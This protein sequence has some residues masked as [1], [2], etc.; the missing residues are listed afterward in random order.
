VLPDAD[1]E[2][3]GWNAHRFLQLLGSRSDGNN[4]SA[5]ECLASPYTIRT[6]PV[7]PELTEY[8]DSNY[9]VIELFNHYRGFAKSNWY[10]YLE[11]G[12]D[13]TVKRLL[14]VIR[15]VLFGEYVRKVKHIPPLNLRTFL[16]DAP[17]AVFTGIDRPKVEELID[18][19][20]AGRGDEKLDP[21]PYESCVEPFIEQ[22]IDYQELVRE[23][24]M[25]AETLDWYFERMLHTTS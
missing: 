11:S 1:I 14:H 6:H 10:R 13:P 3:M 5:I 22:E 2:F 17:D 24:T 23:D 4:P 19:K 9:N 21:K 18:L 15:A 25:D 16:E 12:R 20:S 7:I 8:V